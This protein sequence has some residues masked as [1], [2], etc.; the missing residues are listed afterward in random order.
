MPDLVGFQTRTT[1]LGDEII[2]LA[3]LWPE[4]PRAMVV[5]LNP[6]PKSVEAGHY[7][8]GRAGQR[9]L[10]R[11][12][13]AGI[14]GAP[15][16]SHFEAS[17]LEAGIGFTDLVKRPTRSERDVTAAAELAHGKRELEAALAARGIP[18]VI[19]VFRHPVDALL[20]RTEAPGVQSK[21]ASWGATV[22]RMP[23]P[24]APTA[25]ADAVMDMLSPLLARAR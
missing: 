3:D 18:L 15:N 8:Q 7:Y 10:M 25:E 9:Q 12:V 17:A 5:G 21:R 14:I 13:D 20:G 19:C 11:L 24:Y 22:F 23:G 1:W 16:G 4:H 2:T 6:A